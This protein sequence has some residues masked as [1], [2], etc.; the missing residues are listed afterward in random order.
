MRLAL[1]PRAKRLLRRLPRTSAYGVIELILLLVL[2]VQCARLLWAVVTPVDP[3]GQW[4]PLNGLTQ[5]AESR[6][7]LLGAFDPFFRQQAGTAGAVVTSLQLTLFGV[8]V[9]EAM[10]RG[11]AIVAGPDGV[12]NSYGVG[13]EILPGV[14]LKSV[15]FDSVTISRGGADEQLFLDQSGA[16]PS[17]PL[18]DQADT[19]T[20]LDS[21]TSAAVPGSQTVQPQALLSEIDFAPRLD[22]GQITGFVVKPK[23]AGTAFRVAGLQDG[24]IVVSVNNQK[25]ANAS[26][27]ERIATEAGA[28]GGNVSLQVERGSQVIPLVITIARQ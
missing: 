1:D 13:E 16:A 18:P 6:A 17:V 20:L 7:R 10:G 25:I 3:L 19:S 27:L 26:D 22:G 12:Q 14:T 23:G 21:P 11:S 9:D 4:R 28:K 5:G 8:R 15:Q 24:D 2:A